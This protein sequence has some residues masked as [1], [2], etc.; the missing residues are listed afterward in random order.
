MTDKEPPAQG[1]GPVTFTFGDNEPLCNELL[2]LVR[3]GKKTATCDALIMF[4]NGGD[5]MPVVGRQDIALN[6]D[7]TPALTLETVEVF[8]S[9]FCDVDEDFALAEG[10]N[11]SLEGWRRDHRAYFERS[12]GFDQE[13]MLVCERFT[14]VRDH[15][16]DSSIDTNSK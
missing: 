16:A 15:V 5:A 9:R 6:W 4:E 7:G 12:S 11:E 14:L 3:E 13:M 1:E 10:E 2:Q 8:R